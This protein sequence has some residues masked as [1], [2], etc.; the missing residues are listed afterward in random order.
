M[1]SSSDEDENSNLAPDEPA[2]DDKATEVQEA[3]SAASTEEHGKELYSRNPLLT[4]LL[5]DKTRSRAKIFGM[6]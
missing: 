2:G 4:F 6:L 5:F 3:T 1:F